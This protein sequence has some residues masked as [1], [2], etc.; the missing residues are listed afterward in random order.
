MFPSGQGMARF[1]KD[2]SMK[3]VAHPHEQT[4][5]SPQFLLAIQ[6]QAI[7]DAATAIAF[8]RSSFKNAG[9]AAVPEQNPFDLTVLI[10]YGL[11]LRF[12]RW[13]LNHIRV[14]LDAGLPNGA[15]V[16]AQM[17]KLGRGRRLTEFVA[18]LM[19]RSARVFHE[20]FLWSLDDADIGSEIAIVGRLDDQFLDAI[21]QFLL[22]HVMSNRE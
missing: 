21:T 19:V 5:F 9:A 12:R 8:V 18:W 3:S 2:D 10:G 15:G 20:S 1:V 4:E 7:S 16:L 6:A 22:D 17:V 14:H 13:E 11:A